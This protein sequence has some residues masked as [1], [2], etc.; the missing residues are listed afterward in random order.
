[1]IEAPCKDC[2]GEGV[3][4][5]RREVSV[6]IPAGIE[7]GIVLR[8]PGAGDPAPRGGEPGH[9]ECIVRVEPHEVFRR[10][11]DD[12]ADLV[13]DVPVPLSTAVLG[14]EVEVPSLEG[15]ST[16]R[17]EASSEPGRPLRIR[18]AGLPRLRHSGRGDLW[19]RVLY[20][21][22]ANPGKKLRK[23]LEALAEAEREE[24]GPARRRFAD[25]VKAHRKR[26]D[27]RKK[28]P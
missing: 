16:I 25:Q 28:T 3:K 14:G 19:V 8:I 13:V 18:G 27:S 24:S 1:V 21:V 7:D 23:A 22:P 10:S 17:V 11:E 9:L 5:I 6:K 26:T 2:D 4:P 15:V 12:P 20:D